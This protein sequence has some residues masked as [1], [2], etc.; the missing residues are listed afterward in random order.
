[1]PGRRDLSFAS[2]FVQPQSPAPTSVGLGFRTSWS[3]PQSWPT[4]KQAFLWSRTQQRLFMS[5]GHLY[6]K[7]QY[8]P[9]H[10]LTRAQPR[11]GRMP[12][13]LSRRMPAP[14]IEANL[15]TTP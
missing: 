12:D 5:N 3:G 9:G 1:M 7:S 2:H 10:S 13:S 14:A 8:Y 11:S 6:V 15:Q 4:G